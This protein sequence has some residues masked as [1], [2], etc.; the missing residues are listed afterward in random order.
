MM[1]LSKRKGFLTSTMKHILIYILI[2]TL[3]MVSNPKWI[4]KTV[5]SWACKIDR[6]NEQ[7]H[8]VF[9]SAL[10]SHDIS[11]ACSV[12]VLF[13]MKWNL[14]PHNASPHDI[15]TVY[16]IR[17]DTWLL[18]ETEYADSK[19]ANGTIT[20]QR[21]NRKISTHQNNSFCYLGKWLLTWSYYVC[22]TPRMIIHAIHFCRPCFKH[23]RY[24]NFYQF[25]ILTLR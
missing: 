22:T 6:N 24:C 13:T 2:K 1:R 16:L 25:S 10:H 23:V 18:F 12:N 20:D 8:I 14:I 9:A 19:L 7:Y 17:F 11:Y 21:I 4:E 5:C 3:Y 15:F